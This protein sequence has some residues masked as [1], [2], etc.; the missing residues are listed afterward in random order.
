MGQILIV[1]DEETLRFTF[2]RFLTEEGH[3]VDSAGSYR[4]ALARVA[5]TDYDAILADIILGGETGI[6]LLRQLRELRCP[7]PVVMITGFPNVQTATEAVRL[8][9]YDYLPKPVKKETLLRVVRMALQHKQL[10]QE[11]ETYRANLEAIFR[12]VDDA[13]VTIDL[14]ERIVAF[15]DAARRFYGLSDADM[16]VRFAALP[17]GRFGTC[18]PVM[19]ETIRSRQPVQRFRVECVA[20]DGST[21]VVSIKTSP[22]LDSAGVFSGAVMVVRDETRLDNLE[23]NLRARTTFHDLIGKSKRMQEVYAL[24]ESLADVPTTVLVTG[25]SGTGK[26]LVASALHYTGGRGNSPFVR[27][28]CAA[29][30]ETLLESELFGHVRGAFTGAVK[31]KIGRFQRAH[32]GTILL[33]EI[34]DISPALQVRLLR[35]LQEKEIERVGDT[36]PLKVDVR[37]IAATNR[38]LAEQVRRGRFREDLYYRLKVARIN[39]PPLRDRREDIPLLVDHFLDKF[40]TKFRNRVDAVSIDVLKMLMQYEWPGNVRELE[41][42][43]EHAFILAATPIITIDQLPVDFVESLAG[44]GAAEGDRGCTPQTIRHALEKAGGNKAKA[45]RL[46]GVSRIT[47][48]RKLHEFGLLTGL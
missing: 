24:I 38:D 10:I 46:L 11:R 2:E 43:L 18:K 16:G 33:D 12:S 19:L 7:A 1:D 44:Q 25:E 5:D 9:A 48:Y 37:V 30:A 40:R 17:G 13:I 4:E 20:V 22:L 35:V 39:L 3:V 47:L 32:G 26:E 21:A 8:G 27:V 14:D 29:L 45:A 41:H 34:G 31:D 23:Q 15:N 36:T 28:N 6:E 42:L